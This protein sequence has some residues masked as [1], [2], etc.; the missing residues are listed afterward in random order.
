MQ[1]MEWSLKQKLSPHMGN[2]IAFHKQAEAV[3][4]A[5]QLLAM[6]AEWIGREGYEYWDDESYALQASLLRNA[7]TELGAASRQPDYSR[8]RQAA[9]RAE[10][11]C[12]N[13]HEDYRG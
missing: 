11:A 4:H 1:H 7:A 8:A 12:S 5:A 3:G 2:K 6:L 13:C 9:G 10:Q